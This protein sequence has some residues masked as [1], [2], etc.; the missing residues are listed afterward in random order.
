MGIFEQ[1][2]EIEQADRRRPSLS[3]VA[4]VG[5]G[6]MVGWGVRQ[7]WGM[8]VTL[9]WL[10]AL[11]VG[12][13]VWGWWGVLLVAALAVVPFYVAHM[14]GLQVVTADM[15]RNAA[16]AQ[17]RAALVAGNGWLRDVRLV[18]PSDE[19]L[20]DCAL[21]DDG[22]TARLTLGT[23][24]AGVKSSAVAQAARDYSDRFDAS[25]VKVDDLGGGALSIAFRRSHPL[26]EAIVWSAPDP[27]FPEDMSVV[28]AVDEDGTP[29]KVSFKDNS[30]MVI[31]GI[32]G[33]GKTAA[34]SSFLSAFALSE[35]VDMSVIDCKGGTDWDTY[36]P[37]ASS[38]L[39][40][41]GEPDEIRELHA[42]VMSVKA[43]MIERVRTNKERLGSSN[44]W[45]VSADAR[46]RAGVPFRL[47]VID[48]AHEIFTLKPADKELR[49]MVTEIQTAL[50]SIVKRGRSAGV[51]MVF[52][53]QKPTTD[54]LPSGLRD[55]CG[56]RIAL[57]MTT[58]EGV[59]AI[60]GETL[61]DSLDTPQPTDIPQARKGGAVMGKETGEAV[62]VRFV[63]IP[64]DKLEKLLAG[65]DPYA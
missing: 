16:H 22:D 8:R 39:S 52:I 15:R 36:R 24:I 5:L 51:G 63:Y 4:G 55:N 6:R 1:A 61:A 50:T 60:M 45:N 27:L 30:G 40:F 62:M 49:E 19:A 7:M 44:F 17:E 20:Y 3:T 35:D 28:C 31:G 46:R 43:E 25:S 37:R 65:G 54:S 32:V 33:S 14:A 13:N 53:T 9:G 11:I 21:M 29:V 12:A 38:F 42:M 34:A 57:R 56:I 64:E 23:A 10:V 47:V 59:R 48:E 26:D 41:A 58:A 18:A 2:R